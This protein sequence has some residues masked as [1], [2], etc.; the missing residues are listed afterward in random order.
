[1]AIFVIPLLMGSST[2]GCIFISYGYLHRPQANLSR[3][4]EMFHTRQ[5][6]YPVLVTVYHALECH[7]VDIFPLSVGYYEAEKTPAS[8]RRLLFKDVEEEGW[9]LFSID[10][11]NTYGLPFEVT[12]ERVQKGW[13]TCPESGI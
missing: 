3:P 4:P 12:L 8:A 13:E 7:N 9:C 5:V 2:S 11:R 6:P 1:M 10:V